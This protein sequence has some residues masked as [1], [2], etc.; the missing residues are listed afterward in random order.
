MFAVS[1]RCPFD[2]G[3]FVIARAPYRERRAG[4]LKG[5]G[6]VTR[7]EAIVLLHTMRTTWYATHPQGCCLLCRDRQVWSSVLRW[8]LELELYLR[9]YF[10]GKGDTILNQFCAWTGV[11]QGSHADY[12]CGH[13]REQERLFLSQMELLCACV[14]RMIEDERIAT[15]NDAHH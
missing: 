11:W 12:G 14:Q 13:N 10:R 7:E 2:A 8:L 3:C 4:A 1:T 6:I 9:G 5:Y 15:G